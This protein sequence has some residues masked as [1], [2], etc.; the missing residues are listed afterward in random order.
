M[1][2]S[3]DSSGPGP[4]AKFHAKPGRAPGKK[5]PHSGRKN[6]GVRKMSEASVTKKERRQHR[7]EQKE[8][9]ALLAKTKAI[10]EQLRR[11][12]REKWRARGRC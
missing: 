9:H 6:L 10:W 1:E 12:E 7:R 4:A 5:E 2:R 3:K 11:W 8:N